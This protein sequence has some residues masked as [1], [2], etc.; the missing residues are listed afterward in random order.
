MNL[1]I[2]VCGAGL[3]LLVLVDLYVTVL[4]PRGGPGPV[5]RAIFKLLWP[6]FTLPYRFSRRAGEAVLAHAGPIILVAPLFAWGMLLVLG[7]ALIVW[8][9][10]GSAIMATGDEATSTDF[11]S[12]LYYAGVSFTTLGYGD[13]VPVTPFFHILSFVKAGLGFS[14][15]TLV[16]AYI[17]AVYGALHQRTALGLSIHHR[18]GDSGSAAAYLA[19]LLKS[20]N[21]AIVQQ[22]L[23]SFADRLS[24][25][26]ESH[27]FYPVMHYFRLQDPRY[28]MARIVFLALDTAALARAALDEEAYGWLIDSLAIEQLWQ[29]GVHITRN[30]SSDHMPDHPDGHPKAADTE[31]L[32]AWEAHLDAAVGALEKHGVACHRDAQERLRRYAR[33]REEWDR[34]VKAFTRFMRY[35]WCDIT[36]DGPS[37]HRND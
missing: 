11:Y 31:D 13:L 15:I 10:L 34:P 9:A 14:M 12:A 35:E 8:P 25:Y 2:Q 18:T 19:T 17:I 33:Q 30:L 37:R 16:L 4:F 24:E 23:S 26:D 1:F 21:R 3:V 32:E 28:A 7:F 6:L 5:S 29:S 22:D 36:A 27:H 20:P